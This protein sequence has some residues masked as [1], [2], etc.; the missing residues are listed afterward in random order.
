MALYTHEDLPGVAL[1]LVGLV[2]FDDPEHEET[3]DHPE[4]VR[5]VMGGDDREHVVYEHELRVLDD[6]DYCTQCG[7]IGCTHDGRIRAE[8]Y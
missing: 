7:Q 1:R 3:C 4:R 6:N 5:I 2:A 8:D